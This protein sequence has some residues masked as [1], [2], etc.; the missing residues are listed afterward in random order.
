LPLS[1]NWYILGPVNDKKRDIIFEAPRPTVAPALKDMVAKIEERLREAQE[2]AADV[3]I[4]PLTIWFA[5]TNNKVS[6]S[7]EGALSAPR[8][9]VAKEIVHAVQN[10]EVKPDTNVGHRDL[11]EVMDG[12]QMVRYVLCVV[13]DWKDKT[14]RT[15]FDRNDGDRFLGAM[16]IVVEHLQKSDAEWRK[17]A[18]S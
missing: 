4:A 12:R 15:N 13:I 7:I 8:H 6:F 2:T 14:I 3:H 18:P 5:I 11:F 9:V 1:D 17:G 16:A 10:F